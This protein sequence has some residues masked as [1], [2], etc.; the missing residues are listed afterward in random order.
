MKQR[1]TPD[2]LIRT[3]SSRKR[4]FQNSILKIAKGED[5]KKTKKKRAAPP[6]KVELNIPKAIDDAPSEAELNNP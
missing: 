2:P 1:T 6:A 4:S 5:T 3:S